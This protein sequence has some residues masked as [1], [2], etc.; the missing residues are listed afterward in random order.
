[1]RLVNQVCDHALLLSYV[2]GRRTIE[3]AG[4]EEAWAD[5]QQLPAPSGTQSAGET[6]DG[7]VIEFGSLDDASCGAGTGAMPTLAVG[8]ADAG[9]DGGMPTASVGMAPA[10]APAMA[11][12]FRVARIEDEETPP[13]DSEPAAQIHRIEQLLAEADEDFQPAGSI[14]PEVEL[15]FEEAIHP[16]REEFEH[17]E[18][19]SDRYAAR[20]AAPDAPLA[21]SHQRRE[22]MSAIGGGMADA[23]CVGWDTRSAVPPAAAEAVAEAAV[24][25]MAE[26]GGGTALRLSH[27]TTTATTQTLLEP[28][29]TSGGVAVAVA[30]EPT[31]AIEPPQAPPAVRHEFRHLFARLRRG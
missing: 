12:V 14:G 29:P 9:E 1:V 23:S 2:A 19:V 7:G 31:A 17:E 10:T 5:L 26:P 6:A 28:M 13:D 30:P 25:T 15:C 20:S 11:S 8:M 27:P 18:V 21:A 4:I 3:P 24:E 22:S 16:F